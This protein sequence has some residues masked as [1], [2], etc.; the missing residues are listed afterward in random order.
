[1]RVDRRPPVSGSHSGAALAP[2]MVGGRRRTG[3]GGRFFDSGQ[4]IRR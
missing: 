1:M 4:A 3:R 2:V